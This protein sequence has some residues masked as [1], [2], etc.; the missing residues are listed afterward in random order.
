[1]TCESRWVTKK[2][3]I[4]Y[5]L[6]AY[7]MLSDTDQPEDEQR[8]S[9]EVIPALPAL[10][11]RRLCISAWF[12]RHWHGIVLGVIIS[13]LLWCFSAGVGKGQAR[14]ARSHRHCILQ[15]C[16]RADRCVQFECGHCR[17]SPASCRVCARNG[18]VSMTRTRRPVVMCCCAFRPVERLRQHEGL[19]PAGEV[20]D[21]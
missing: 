8:A 4:N 17:S 10:L 16:V 12:V 20:S 9:L 11:C 5:F 3:Y 1:V 2:Q 19:P 6:L 7:R 21:D 18:Y 15:G 13:L 14:A